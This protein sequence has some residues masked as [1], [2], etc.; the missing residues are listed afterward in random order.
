VG[1]HDPP[2]SEVIFAWEHLIQEMVVIF[3]WEHLI[4]KTVKLI[5]GSSRSAK[6]SEVL[7]REQAI[8]EMVKS[9]CKGM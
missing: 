8:Q 7:L 6:N 9:M 2:N 1:G 4:Q 3:V 5:C